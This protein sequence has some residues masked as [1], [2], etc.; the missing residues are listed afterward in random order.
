[1]TNMCTY[2]F[3]AEK[4][5]EREMKEKKGKISISVRYYEDVPL[6]KNLNEITVKVHNCKFKG[7]N[8]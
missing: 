3:Y 1:M 4:P 7:C 2:S 6:P 8:I 5:K